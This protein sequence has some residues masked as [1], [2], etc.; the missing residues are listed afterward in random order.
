MADNAASTLRKA[1][2]KGEINKLK[3]LNANGNVDVNL[4]NYD[5]RTALHVAAS[6]GNLKAVECLVEDLEA[7]INVEDR[8]GGTP[9]DDALRNNRKDVAKYLTDKGACVGKTS[10][11]GDD[12][13]ILC[14]AAS[15]ADLGLL[16]VLAKRGV[17]INLGDYD[18]RTAVHLAASEGKLKVVKCLVDELNAN[19]NVHDRWSGTP[20]DDALRSGNNN[21]FKYLKSK[22]GK[23]GKVT[24]VTA[25]D[26][27]AL[28]DAAASG[29]TDRL[30]ELVVKKG[31]DVNMADY[32]DRTALH[33]AVSEG[34]M[35]AVTYL[36]EELNANVNVKDRYGGTPLDDATRSGHPG[37]VE[38]LVGR[39]ALR[40]KTAIYMDTALIVVVD[41]VVV[42]VVG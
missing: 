23:S 13:G 19:P 18:G 37:I 39:G 26:A 38:Y 10:F 35:L 40:G 27:T 2:F 7:D 41:V 32:D 11:P 14:D 6:T 36:I 17:D 28:C 42:V 24:T 31:L 21:V 25:V 5:A 1:A 20:L 30:T 4:G 15:K 12:S 34:L 16:R 3:D 8:F 9:L 29:N 33:L 22:G